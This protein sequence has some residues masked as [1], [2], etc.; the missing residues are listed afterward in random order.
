M[1]EAL[2]LGLAAVMGSVTELGLAMVM[3]LVTGLEKEWCSGMG[4]N[5]RGL[6]LV[7]P[8]W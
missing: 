4:L 1:V 7:R 2:A 8:R 5:R 3:G 6:W